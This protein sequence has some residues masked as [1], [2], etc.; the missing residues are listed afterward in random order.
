GQ[1]RP[2]PGVD[3]VPRR[4]GRDRAERTRRFQS[5]TACV[6]GMGAGLV[7]GR[8]ARSRAPEGRDEPAFVESLQG[9]RS[10]LQYAG[11]SAG[12]FVQRRLS[13]GPA[14]RLSGMVTI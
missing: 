3:G 4:T 12:V 14:E 9:E 6:S 8:A 7:R 2:P 13:D 11:V 1:R 10:A 5:R